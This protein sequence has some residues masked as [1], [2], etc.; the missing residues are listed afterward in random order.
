MIYINMKKNGI[1][2]TI[3]KFTTYKEAKKMVQEYNLS[4]SCNTYY[5][6]QRSTKEWR[7]KKCNN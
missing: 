2:E 1:V 3:D 6:S 4:D 5:L 7:L